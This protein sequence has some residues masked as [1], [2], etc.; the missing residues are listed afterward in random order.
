M[1][2]QVTLSD[3]LVTALVI[4]SITGLLSLIG[5]GVLM[6]SRLGRVEQRVDSLLDGARE[7]RHDRVERQRSLDADFAAVY[8]RLNT[9]EQTVAGIAATQRALDS[10]VDSLDHT[11][12]SFTQAVEALGRLLARI[13]GKESR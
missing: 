2:A 5:T 8:G 9:A 13:D 12:G 3:G 11:L 7:D 1:I 4:G 10:T 6:F